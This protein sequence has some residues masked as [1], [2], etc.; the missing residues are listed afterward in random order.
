M[1]LNNNLT[2][3]LLIIHFSGTDLANFMPNL[4]KTD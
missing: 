4:T 1:T 2:Y 3:F